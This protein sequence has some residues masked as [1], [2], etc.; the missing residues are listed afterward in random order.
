[1]I[2]KIRKYGDDFDIRNNNLIK[3]GDEPLTY[4]IFRTEFILARIWGRV[5]ETLYN[6]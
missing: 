2:R 4:K 5:K 1:M 3:E 6:K